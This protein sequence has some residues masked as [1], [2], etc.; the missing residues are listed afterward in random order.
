[1]GALD[2]GVVCESEFASLWL[3]ECF[4]SRLYRGAQTLSHLTEKEMT[5]LYRDSYWQI[6]A[7]N[8]WV[9]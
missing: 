2:R 8:P 3:G 7:L 5:L 4:F 9:K 1:M 6:E